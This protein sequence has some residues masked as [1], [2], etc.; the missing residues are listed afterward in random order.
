MTN[1]EAEGVW[2]SKSRAVAVVLA[3]FLGP[4]GLLYWSPKLAGLL[5]IGTVATLG[6]GLLIT[7]P[8]AIIVAGFGSPNAWSTVQQGH[9]VH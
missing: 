3:V 1:V 2:P 5:L 8:W 9:R 4:F 7:W 6:L